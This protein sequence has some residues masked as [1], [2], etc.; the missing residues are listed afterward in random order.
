MIISASRRTDIPAFYSDWFMNRV[1]EGFFY[2]V[3]P[4]NSDQISGFSLDPKDVDAI[5]FWTKNPE[6]L[7]RHLDELDEIGLNYYFQFTLNPY[8][9]IFEPNTPSL[10]G[11]IETFQRLADKIGS[12]RVVWRYD[13][14]ILTSA[15]NVDWHLEQVESI[16]RQLESS[17]ERLV[18]SFYDFYG[19]GRGRLHAALEGSGV[20]LEDI[21]RHENRAALETI[22]KGFKTTAD[23][24]QFDIFSCSEDFDLS[25]NEIEHGAC[26]DGTLIR[27]LF[28][29]DPS[30]KKDKNQR[31]AC[32]CVESVD[33]GIYNTCQFRCSYCYANYNEGVIEGNR[34]KHDV[35]D[36]ALLG[37]HDRTIEI[38]EVI[39]KKKKRSQ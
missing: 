27:Q 5:C 25:A 30:D 12:E 34:I 17:T 29:G 14:V 8:G 19:K 39:N 10:E 20:I 2:R 24:Y 21:T 1:R 35:N 36:P 13:P 16:A 3:N 38:Q 33:M 28:G 18:F 6:P 37:Q 23:R 22:V 4:F 32:G 9:K 26:I 7:M 11:R 15:T 31:Q